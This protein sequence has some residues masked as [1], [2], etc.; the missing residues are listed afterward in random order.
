MLE[1]KRWLECRGLNKTGVKAELVERVRNGLTCVDKL[2]IDPK[3]D[4]GV[5]YQMKATKKPSL[6]EI[7]STNQISVVLLGVLL[8]KQTH[9]HKH[10]T[11]SVTQRNR[12]RLTH[13]QT[14]TST[15]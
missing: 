10:G 13:R 12:H 7:I 3:V 2:P 4:N 6:L 15:E 8:D 1:L 14:D 11:Q 5:P 9:T